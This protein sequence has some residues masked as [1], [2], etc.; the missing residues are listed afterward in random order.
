M[1]CEHTWKRSR[2]FTL[3][4]RKLS[5]S[6]KITAQMLSAPILSEYPR[7]LPPTPHRTDG[8]LRP[9]GEQPV[10]PADAV[11][12]PRYRVLRATASTGRAAEK[13]LRDQ[14]V[15]ASGWVWPPLN[16]APCQSAQPGVNAPE[17]S[18]FVLLLPLHLYKLGEFLPTVLTPALRS[19]LFRDML[20][21]AINRYTRN[22]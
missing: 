14:R 5:P 22:A 9:S 17:G 4:T 8:G 3:L 21:L 12:P 2:H 20:M 1:S 16:P 7:P 11:L 13:P 18:G 19:S 15:T 6:L 10:P